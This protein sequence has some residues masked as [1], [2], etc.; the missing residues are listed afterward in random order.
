[1]T[2]EEAF[3]A[4]AEVAAYLKTK[5]G[6]KKVVLFGSTAKGYFQAPN[7][8]IDIYIHFEGISREQES[9][10]LFHTWIAFPQLKLDL[11]PP[12]AVPEY[13]LEEIKATGVIL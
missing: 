4:A 9:T 13:L 3:T 8:D 2:Q 7:S 1:M 10:I 11:F 6:V 12:W 5:Q